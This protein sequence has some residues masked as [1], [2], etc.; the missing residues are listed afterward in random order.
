MVA[1]GVRG[2][3]ER[4]AVQGRCV[5]L[6]ALDG[7][8]AEATPGEF[9]DDVRRVNATALALVQ[10]MAD[11]D[12][13]PVN[14]VWFVTRG[15]QSLERGAGWGTGGGYAVGFGEGGG[16]GSTAPTATDD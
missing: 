6:A 16:A 14:G 3:A 13:T 4:C 2:L 7:H 12:V 10:G 8:G 1:F 5:H 11:A 15:G 9:A